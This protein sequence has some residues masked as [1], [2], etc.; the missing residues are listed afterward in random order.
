MKTK[1]VENFSQSI[2]KVGY[3]NG[4]SVNVNC[5]VKALAVSLRCRVS[6]SVNVRRSDDGPHYGLALV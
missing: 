6:L 4:K 5:V 3:E 1:L 2:L